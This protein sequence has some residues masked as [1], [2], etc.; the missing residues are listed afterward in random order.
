K[1]T[2]KERDSESGLDYFG[3]RYDS[4]LMGR[5][6][7]PDWNTV[8]TAIPF[9]DLQSPQSLNLYSYVH[10]NPIG[11]VDLDGHDCV[12]LNDKGDGVES[13]DHHSSAKECKDTNGAWA[14]GEVQ[15]NNVLTDPQSDEIL[16]V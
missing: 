6:M 11:L 2:G 3:A 8:P 10:N 5:F 12:Y 1:F 4:P 16:I 7:S 13:I 9:G 14:D 15:K